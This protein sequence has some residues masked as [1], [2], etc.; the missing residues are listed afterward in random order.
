MRCHPISHRTANNRA[1][2]YFKPPRP[3]RLPTGIQ[4]NA[5]GRS[6][7]TETSAGF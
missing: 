1:D 5:A 6:R 3:W 2:L 7:M 4:R